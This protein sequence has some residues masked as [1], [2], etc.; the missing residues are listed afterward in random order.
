MRDISLNVMNLSN[1][2]KQPNRI[3][4]EIRELKGG[5]VQANERTNER[6]NERWIVGTDFRKLDEMKLDSFQCLTF[7]Y[8]GDVCDTLYLQERNFIAVLPAR[9]TLWEKKSGRGCPSKRFA[10]ACPVRTIPKAEGRDNRLLHQA[11]GAELMK[12]KVWT[13]SRSG[14]EEKTKTFVPC[15]NITPLRANGIYVRVSF[16]VIAFNLLGMCPW[17]RIR[18][19][20]KSRTADLS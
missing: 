3:P 16:R 11:R 5:R 9:S 14:K 7:F 8:G 1:D 4:V 20:N 2:T 6:T 13:Y 17:R 19:D 10:F 12:E 18:K 15:E